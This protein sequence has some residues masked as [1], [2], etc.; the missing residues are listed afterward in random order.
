MNATS[1]GPS[2]FAPA[3][4]RDADDLWADYRAF[5]TER[6]GVL[7][8]DTGFDKRE[9]AM[10]DM[11]SWGGTFDGRVDPERFRRNYT[12]YDGEGL[13]GPELALLAFCKVNAGEAYG[14]DVTRRARAHL[15]DRDEPIY[16]VEKC[17]AREEDFHTR[18]LVGATQ[19]FEGVEVGGAWSPAWPLRLLIFALATFPTA[20]YHP[21]L[22][23]AEI[24]GVFTFNWLLERLKTVFPRDPQVRESMER[25][26]IEILV[27]EVG[28][29]AFNRV[30]VG[31]LG[32]AVALPLALRINGAVPT[33]VPELGALGFDTHERS[34]LTR[35]DYASLPE[36]VRRRAWFV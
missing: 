4:G 9:A 8:V 20:L 36:E 16:R 19:H 28:H 17:L 7:D 23:G 29:V 22:L 35:F 11:A 27:D 12:A 25:R 24:S 31:R 5:L 34:A 15:L 3:P 30:A 18:I 26:L 21:V 2:F 32:L 6:N 13:T 1:G 10:R 14:V 33:M